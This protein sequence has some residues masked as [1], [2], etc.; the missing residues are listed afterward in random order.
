ME[1]GSYRASGVNRSSGL[2]YRV[3]RSGRPMRT[4][5]SSGGEKKSRLS[6]GSSSFGRNTAG[7]GGDENSLELITKSDN[8][9]GIRS[10]E[11]SS[12]SHR[13][14]MSMEAEQKGAF[15][16]SRNDLGRAM[17]AGRPSDAASRIVFRTPDIDH[18]TNTDE[19]V[20]TAPEGAGY[21]LL[22]ADPSYDMWSMGVVFYRIITRRHLFETDDQDN[23][24]KEQDKRTLH[25]W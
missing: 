25:D 24:S 15:S 18:R 17:G 1:A 4:S 8:S 14:I 3:S 5:G 20:P 10:K 11:K 19:Q 12:G 16:Q 13:R 7:G 21:E 2:D 9:A 23:L 6:L 22:M